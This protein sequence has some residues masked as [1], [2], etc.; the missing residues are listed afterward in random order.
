MGLWRSR[1]RSSQSGSFSP[2]KASRIS[3]QCNRWNTFPQASL[4]QTK[5]KKPFATWTNRAR[6]VQY[7]NEASDGKRKGAI[8]TAHCPPLDC[9]GGKMAIQAVEA[10]LTNAV[11][12]QPF[13]RGPGGAVYVGERVTQNFGPH[14]PGRV[15]SLS[16]CLSHRHARLITPGVSSEWT[17]YVDLNARKSHRTACRCLYEGRDYSQHDVTCEIT[18]PQSYE[19]RLDDFERSFAHHQPLS[20]SL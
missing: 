13:K 9:P 10:K 5:V 15:A 12:I 20:R 7:H 4:T 16:D 3:H 19:A 6:S 18:R 1:G 2:A 17:L 14:Q 11:P 8:F